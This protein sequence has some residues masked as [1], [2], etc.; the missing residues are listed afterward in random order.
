MLKPIS[1]ELEASA[2][3]FLFIFLKRL[4]EDRDISFP[5]AMVTY[6]MEP[7]Y[8]LCARNDVGV[9]LTEILL[10]SEPSTRP[11]PTIGRK[12]APTNMQ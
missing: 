1:S 7:M 11:T 8:W 10:T 4:R 6:Y 3:L 9:T 5:H 12:V 2:F